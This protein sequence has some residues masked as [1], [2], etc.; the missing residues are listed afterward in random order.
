MILILS[1]HMVLGAFVPLQ[2]KCHPEVPSPQLSRVF[3]VINA[4]RLQSQPPP[5]QEIAVVKGHHGSCN[6]FQAR[7]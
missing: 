7:L 6:A 1:S 5:K 3:S 2:F 4:G